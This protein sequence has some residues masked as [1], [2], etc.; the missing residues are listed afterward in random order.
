M[1]LLIMNIKCLLLYFVVHTS[2]YVENSRYVAHVFINLL[3]HFT[4]AN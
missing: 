2:N 1:N 4:S 3:S